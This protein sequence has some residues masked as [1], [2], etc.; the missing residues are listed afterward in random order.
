M[1]GGSSQLPTMLTELGST[2]WFDYCALDSSRKLGGAAEHLID[3]SEKCIYRLTFEF[4]SPHVIER[5][6]EV[7]F[8]M[9]IQKADSE[10]NIHFTR[11]YHFTFFFVVNSS[12]PGNIVHHHH[13]HPY[14]SS[15]MIGVFVASIIVFLVFLISAV[16]IRRIFRHEPANCNEQH[17][18][19]LTP[20]LSPS[21]R[22][23]MPP[24]SSAPRNNVFVN[25]PANRRGPV[26]W[27]TTV[28]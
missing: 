10:F 6:N 14:L 5:R 28:I 2:M 19:A 20:M 7:L 17:Q 11:N 24:S 9:K 26:R 23:A 13:H 21:S 25:L 12:G 15:K 8:K 3:V 16:V 27:V 18:L 4:K 1:F 22:S